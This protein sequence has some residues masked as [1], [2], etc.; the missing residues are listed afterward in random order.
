MRLDRLIL[1]VGDLRASREF[2]EDRLGFDAD[3]VGA[4]TVSYAAGQMVICLQ[5]AADHGVRLRGERDRS[6]DITLLVDDLPEMRRAL[7]QRGVRVSRTLEYE[8]GRTADFYDPDGHWYSIYEP[9]AQALGWPSGEKILELATSEPAGDRLERHEVVY[10]FVFV[11]E[12]D[13]TQAF[14]HETLGLQ[15]LEGGPCRRGV[16][17]L[18]AGVVKY[19]AGATLLTTHAV[20]DGHAHA[21][22]VSVTGSGELAM[23]FAVPDV[24]SARAGLAGRGV[25]LSDGA[26]FTDPAGHVYGLREPAIATARR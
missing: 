15:A 21:H 10:L 23:V 14:Y 22:R 17:H 5:R 12:P 24:A 16:T 9:S 18:P 8:V 26:R 25:A 11:A 3:E 19:D 1:Y 7:E 6:V 4:G 2:Y 13:A 20:D